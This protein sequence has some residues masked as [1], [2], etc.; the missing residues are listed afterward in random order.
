MAGKSRWER[1]SCGNPRWRP[2]CFTWE[3]HLSS[4]SRPR[5]LPEVC[6]GCACAQVRYP[7]ESDA[8]LDLGTCPV[9][10]DPPGTHRAF[11]LTLGTA[12][13]PLC[14]PCSG[15]GC[16]EAPVPAC[17]VVTLGWWL[18][19]PYRAACSSRIPRC[20]DPPEVHGT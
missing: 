20:S 16:S 3:L 9:T 19:C 11:W 12:R 8:W 7:T 6:G 14:S 5:P 15:T 4:S 2:P 17:L 1:K 13:G 10:A 18:A